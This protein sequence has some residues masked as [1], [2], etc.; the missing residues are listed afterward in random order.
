MKTPKERDTLDLLELVCQLHSRSLNTG[1][2]E[3]HDAYMEARQELERRIRAQ[4]H[5]TNT[6]NEYIRNYMRKH[7]PVLL[8]TI[9]CALI[10]GGLLCKLFPHKRPVM[11]AVTFIAWLCSALIYL[12]LAE[13]LDDIDPENNKGTIL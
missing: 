7:I 5:R 13:I 3:I 8:F 2:K 1:T 6:A 4:N 12:T 10:F 11:V 9:V